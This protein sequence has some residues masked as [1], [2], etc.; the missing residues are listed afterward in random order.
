MQGI[1]EKVFHI[2]FITSEKSKKSIK[3]L[4]PQ[5]GPKPLILQPN[6]RFLAKK[7]TQKPPNGHQNDKMPEKVKVQGYCV[8]E[9]KAVSLSQ[10]KSTEKLY[11]YII[12]ITSNFN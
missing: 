11:Q 10:S 1:F 7:T 4:L 6:P 5:K 12:Y 8:N 3:K 9:K 2:F